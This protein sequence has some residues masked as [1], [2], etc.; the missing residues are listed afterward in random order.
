MSKPKIYISHNY[1]GNDTELVE[2]I[3]ELF[4]TKYEN[5]LPITPF[6][7]NGILYGINTYINNVNM[8]FKLLSKCE[9]MIVFGNKSNSPVC[10]MEKKYCIE[11]NIPI[12]EFDEFKNI[13]FNKYGRTCHE[14]NKQ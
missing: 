5:V 2:N 10:M 8:C 3:L 4:K 11:N 1:G 7:N 9:A 13:Y 12:I 6:N 14:E